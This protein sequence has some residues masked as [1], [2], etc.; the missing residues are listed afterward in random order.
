MKPCEACKA[1]TGM[2]SATPPH[3]DLSATGS[4]M[5]GQPAHPVKRYDE[6]R[7][8]VC[9]NWMLRNAQ[10]GDPPGIWSSTA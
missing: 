1:L 2:P 10:D 6:Y 9:G 3:G 7:C 4:R 8:T 5:T